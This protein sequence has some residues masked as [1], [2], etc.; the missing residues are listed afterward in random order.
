MTGTTPESTH[1]E[2]SEVEWYKYFYEISDAAPVVV[3]E[4]KYFNCNIN[5]EMSDK[6]QV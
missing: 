2:K 6:C 5:E 3:S 1:L 4:A